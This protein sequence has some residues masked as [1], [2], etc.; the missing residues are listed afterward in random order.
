[1]TRPV[2]E[3]AVNL[4]RGFEELRLK[5]YHDASGFPTQGWGRLLSREKWAPLHQW[6]DIDEE[7]A[8][9]WFQEDLAEKAAEVD[10]LLEVE[11]TDNQFGALVSF[12]FNV[13][14]DIDA[15][16]IAEGLGDSTLLRKLNHGDVAGASLEFPKWNKSQ[17]KVLKGLT[18]RRLAEQELFLTA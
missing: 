7:T 10:S 4:I 3:A 11:T 6:P 18:R 5:A 17:G 12:A 14:S 1:M 8:E 13:G 16:T 2:C 9:R 15:D